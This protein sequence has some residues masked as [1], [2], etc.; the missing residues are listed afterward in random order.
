[1]LAGYLK[2]RWAQQ[3]SDH[4]STFTGF[5]NSVLDGSSKHCFDFYDNK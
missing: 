5:V 1:M 2:Y 3:E 4:V